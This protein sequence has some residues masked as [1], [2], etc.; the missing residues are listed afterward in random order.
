MLGFERVFGPGKKKIIIM[1]KLIDTQ[2]L[3]DSSA[4]EGHWKSVVL[5]K[6]SGVHG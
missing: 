5:A 6:P 1:C 2:K 3:S 4:E